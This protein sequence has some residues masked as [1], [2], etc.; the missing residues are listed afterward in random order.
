VSDK[1]LELDQEELLLRMQLALEASGMG[2][3]SWDTT[4]GRVEWDA[5]T[6]ALYGLEP[7]TFPGTYEAYLERLHPE[8]RESAVRRIDRSLGGGGMHRIQHRTVRPDGAV[9]WIEG[10]GRVV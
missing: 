3:W 1:D 5:A 8:D 7:G 10:W 2:T 4:T 6:E 9:R